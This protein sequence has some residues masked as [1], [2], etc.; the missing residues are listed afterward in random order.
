M[1]AMMMTKIRTSLR[2][3]FKAYFLIFPAPQRFDT[4]VALIGPTG[5]ASNSLRF[6]YL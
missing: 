4:V 6:Y 1:Q 3:E 5:G 2:G